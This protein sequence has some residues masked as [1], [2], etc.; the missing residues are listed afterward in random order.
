MDQEEANQVF[1]GASLRQARLSQG[2]TLEDVSAQLRL[3]E[4]QINA[5]EEDDFEGFGSAMLTR[6]FIKNYARLLS[7]DSEQFLDVHRKIVPNDLVQSIAYSSELAVPLANSRT[8]RHAVLIMSVS[9]IVLAL[10]G[11]LTYLSL[12]NQK[13]IDQA[14]IELDS[15]SPLNAEEKALTPIETQVVEAPISNVQDG[16]DFKM[17]DASNVVNNES[18][19]A[20][21]L[22][23]KPDPLKVE[24][25][26]PQIIVGGEKITLKFTEESW[27]SIQDKNYKTILSK[28]WRAGDVEDVEG[29]PP[30]RV[31]IGNANGTQV[32]LK[33]KNIDLTPYNKSNVVHITLPLE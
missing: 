24:A 21:N 1:I 11:L 5:L 3:S 16:Q 23:L 14:E 9:L 13:N 4:K 8:N 29:L 28:L 17:S 32:I 27:V 19:S 7:L 31:V 22:T 30:L 6:G 2:L 18:K 33:N 25:P 15:A 12:S 20:E 26:K 10:I